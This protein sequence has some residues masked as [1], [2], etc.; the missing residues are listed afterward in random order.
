MTQEN[1]TRTID[2]VNMFTGEVE[3]G[4]IEPGDFCAVRYTLDGRIEIRVDKDV[5]SL[6]NKVRKG[7]IGEFVARALLEHL[8]ETLIAELHA[9]VFDLFAEDHWLGRIEV[10]FAVPRRAHNNTQI[11][12]WEFWLSAGDTKRNYAETCTFIVCVGIDHEG[13]PTMF[14][15]P[16][17][18]KEVREVKKHLTI[19]L[20]WGRSKYAKYHYPL[21]GRPFPEA[22]R[23]AIEDVACGL[24]PEG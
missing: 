3:D 4:K 13:S 6:K 21:D 17:S 16:S 19:P 1:E 7:K 2:V 9:Q 22:L 5:A 15:L 10:K 24:L 18:C 11:D 23:Q 20:L 14:I 12:R 8:Q